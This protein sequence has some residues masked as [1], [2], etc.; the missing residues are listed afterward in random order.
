MGV[1]QTSISEQEAGVSKPTEC[2]VGSCAVHSALHRDP[3]VAS[4]ELAGA[5]GAVAAAA[6]VKTEIS[7]H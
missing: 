1:A 3:S 6:W 7:S 2:K 4:D 5:Q